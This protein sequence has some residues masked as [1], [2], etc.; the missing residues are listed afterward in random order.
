MITAYPVFYGVLKYV[1]AT[2]LLYLAWTIAN[3]R[4]AEARGAPQGK[5]ITFL[6]AAAFQWA[7][8]KAWVMILGAISTYATI[9]AFPVNMI[10]IAGLFG[11]LGIASGGTWVEMAPRIMTQALGLT[12]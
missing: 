11:S 5:P 10:V 7:N 9:A 12:H 3:A 8:P 2:Y 1:G 4:P 6:Q